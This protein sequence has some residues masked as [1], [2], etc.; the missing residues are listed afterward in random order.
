MPRTELNCTL[1]SDGSSDKA[2]I[3]V[4]RWLLYRC[5]PN[6]PVQLRWADLRQLPRPPKELHE[7]IATSVQLYPCELL[8]VHRDAENP[9][10]NDRRTEINHALDEVRDTPSVIAVIPV[11]MMEAWLLIDETAIRKAA[12]N[13][14]GQVPLGMPKIG[15]TEDI[16]DPKGLL[17][18]LIRKAT[19]L[20]ARRRKNFNV[21]S[22]LHR[23][24]EYIE[25][26]SVLRQLPA[27]LALEEDLVDTIGRR[28]WNKENV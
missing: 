25:D 5:L 3:P 22:A 10:T 28:A 23:V 12:D 26:F 11:R 17:H 27:F 6:R 7:R 19:G 20:S 8:F 16:A 4:L 1:L 21:H 15:E 2:L 9:S 24:S 13:P 18:D 14:N